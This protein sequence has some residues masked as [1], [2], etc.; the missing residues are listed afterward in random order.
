[1]LRRLNNGEVC[2]LTFVTY[3]R[4]TQKGGQLVTFENCRKHRAGA[5]SVG[6][7]GNHNP[8]QPPQTKNPTHE[9]N[10]TIN[11]K[12]AGNEIKKVHT[13]LITKF[14]QQEVVL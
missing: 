11:I 2:N 7:A 6:V 10:G 8:Q 3:N 1:M 12:T 4:R 14:N 13:R 5:V 9:L